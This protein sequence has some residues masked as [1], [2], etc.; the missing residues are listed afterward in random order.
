MKRRIA[1]FATALALLSLTVLALRPIAA[2]VLHVAPA[3]GD[4]HELYGSGGQCRM[5][6]A[7][8]VVS[9]TTTPFDAAG[10]AGAPVF[11]GVTLLAVLISFKPAA[12]PALRLFT[13]PPRPASW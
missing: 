11:L 13:P 10:I 6:A 9:A 4:V 2:D 12:A 1:V 3:A 8:H 7:C 5:V